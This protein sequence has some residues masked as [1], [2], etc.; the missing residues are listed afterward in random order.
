M[1]D[2]ILAVAAPSA[3]VVALI[4]AIGVLV[5][6]WVGTQ[7]TRAYLAKRREIRSDDRPGT[8]DLNPIYQRFK[9][10]QTNGVHDPDVD[11]FVAVFENNVEAVKAAL[12]NG[13]NVNV[14]DKQVLQRH[15]G[16]TI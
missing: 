11:L 10:L 12:K 2:T 1:R 14:R 6:V 16:A 3:A 9:Q 7:Y 15:E 5:G 13:A 8:V 4:L